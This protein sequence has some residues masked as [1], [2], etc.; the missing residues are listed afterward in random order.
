M[1]FKACLKGF[2]GRQ[3]IADDFHH[4]PPKVIQIGPD[5]S[6]SVLELFEDSTPS[7]EGE[8]NQNE[9]KIDGPGS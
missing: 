7:I 9:Q 8:A 1:C 3:C 2:E 4:P 5:P 6:R